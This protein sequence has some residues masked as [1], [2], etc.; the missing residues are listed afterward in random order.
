M[1]DL[2]RFTIS[3]FFKNL[4]A[5]ICTSLE[6]LDEKGIFIE[7]PWKRSGGGGGKTRIIKNAN[8]IEKGAVN[9][10]EVHGHLPKVVSQAFQVEEGHEFFATG[11]S[12]IIHPFSPLVPIIHMNLRYFQLSNGIKWFG[13][14]ID[15][16]PIYI[17]VDQAKYFHQ[18][19]K[20]V[21]DDYRA[22]AYQ[23]FKQQADEYFFL[24][25][26]NETRG[27]GG[28]FFDREI[29]KDIN[30]TFN[31]IK[32]MG[33]LFYPLYSSIIKN[34]A[35]KTYTNREKNWQLLR[36]GRYVEFNLVYDKGTKFGLD[37]DGRT[38]SILASLPPHAS[39]EYDVKHEKGSAEEFT[40]AYLK[41]GVNWVE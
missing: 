21:C 38:E 40:V 36:R 22:D 19:I 39:W 15:L 7:D 41:K 26:R 8:V 32:S 14:G 17:D 3:E 13:G 12:I 11:I 2:S 24:P 10:S 35:D 23:L 25:H 16:T 5:K 1:A 33:E 20:K 29:D 27:I 30:S 28:I 34:N 6:Q 37:T 31:F 9:F 4:Q 18:Q